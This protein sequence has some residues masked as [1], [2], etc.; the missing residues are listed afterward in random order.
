MEVGSSDIYILLTAKCFYEM[1]Y[2]FPFQ[3]SE[4][5]KTLSE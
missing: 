4:E 1:C 5:Q 2:C 3:A